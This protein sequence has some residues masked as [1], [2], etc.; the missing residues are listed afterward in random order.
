MD[1]LHHF[2]R[3]HGAPLFQ[4]SPGTKR[5]F[6]FTGNNNHPNRFVKSQ[7][8]QHVMQRRDQFPVQTVVHFRPIQN[9]MANVLFLFHPQR[10][11]ESL[12]HP[13][14]ADGWSVLPT[15]H[16]LL[17]LAC[18][19]RDGNVLPKCCW[20]ICPASTNRS[21]STPV[22]MPIPCSK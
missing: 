8:I 20:T 5:F 6:P 3:R 13:S 17:V 12:P 18:N 10:H 14:W 16:A 22:S 2:L 15:W 21:M 19:T 7:L 4:V 1:K 11:P 9:E